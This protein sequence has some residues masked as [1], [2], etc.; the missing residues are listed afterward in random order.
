MVKRGVFVPSILGVVDVEEGFGAFEVQLGS[1][2]RRADMR[3]ISVMDFVGDEDIPRWVEYGQQ[4]LIK[5]VRS[6]GHDTNL[7]RQLKVDSFLPYI[8]CNFSS[9]CTK[10][11]VH[12]KYAFHS[13]VAA[14]RRGPGKLDSGCRKRRYTIVVPM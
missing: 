7:V 12:W 10:D 1:V 4:G 3:Q 11:F 8:S 13:A 9:S 2:I 14:A 6:L 5:T